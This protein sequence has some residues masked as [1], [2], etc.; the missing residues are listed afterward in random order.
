MDLEEIVVKSIGIGANVSRA[1]SS[2]GSGLAGLCPQILVAGGITTEVQVHHQFLVEKS[3]VKVT[4]RLLDHGL[5]QA[6]GKS[7]R[8]GLPVFEVLWHGIR[9]PRPDLD[10]VVGPL[11]GICRTRSRGP[12]S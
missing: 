9:Q 10:V 7:V 1:I 4:V 5:W 2:T 12:G 6:P 3:L 11:H 8:V